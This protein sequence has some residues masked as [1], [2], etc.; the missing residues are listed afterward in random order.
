MLKKV[1]QQVERLGFEVL[2]LPLRQ[3]V[4]QPVNIEAKRPL[5][6]LFPRHRLH[7]VA[8]GE[9]AADNPFD[10]RKIALGDVRPSVSSAVT[11]RRS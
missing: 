7:V 6:K 11:T 8:I 5:Q 4:F 2:C 1:I 3:P 10:F 9:I